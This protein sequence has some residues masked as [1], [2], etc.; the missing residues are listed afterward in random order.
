MK[1]QSLEK[2][3]SRVEELDPV[4]PLLKTLNGLLHPCEKLE[5]LVPGLKS[6]HKMD[7]VSS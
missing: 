1:I 6:Q 5:P 2:L 3:F 4:M 7:P